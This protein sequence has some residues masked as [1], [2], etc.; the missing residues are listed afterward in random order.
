MDEF[1]SGKL[2][3][4]NTSQSLVSLAL[5]KVLIRGQLSWSKGEASVIYRSDDILAVTTVQTQRLI[6]TGDDVSF[7]IERLQQDCPYLLPNLPHPQNC[8]K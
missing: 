8:S 6:P 2:L 7:G 4:N 5:S 3:I 1:C